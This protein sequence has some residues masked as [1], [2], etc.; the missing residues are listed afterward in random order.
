MGLQLP[1]WLT[2]PLG[3]IGLTWPDADEELLLQ[4]GRDWIA[5]SGRLHAMAQASNSSAEDVWS[6]NEGTAV[7]AFE[8]WWAG[9]DGPGMRLAE[10]AIA[11]GMIGCALCL[12]AAVTLA[13]KIAFVVQLTTLAIEVAQAIATAVASFGATT[14]EVPGFIAATRVFCRR[15]VKQAVEH[16][17]AVIGDLLERAK[18]LLRTVRRPKF[19]DPAMAPGVTATLRDAMAGARHLGN[20]TAEDFAREFPE[21]GH[22]VNPGSGRQAGRRERQ[23]AS[24][25]RVQRGEPQRYGAFHRRPDR[26]VRE[27]GKLRRVRVHADELGTI[28]M[29]EAQA[30]LAAE[31]FLAADPPEVPDAVLEDTVEDHDWCYVIWWTTRAALASGSY[32]DLPPPG[33][34]P[35]AVDKASGV[36]FYLSSAPLEDSL[37]MARTARGR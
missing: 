35:I 16:V 25:A 7:K 23:A 1:G 13:L 36:P 37:E 15:L 34:G 4:A 6:R 10:D 27:T 19:L 28:E 2:E 21:L 9:A 30:R 3:W 26:T 20:T 12:F 14:A 33:Y 17:R 8:T 22:G 18:G 29:D 32:D 11:A 24:G 5:F 31:A